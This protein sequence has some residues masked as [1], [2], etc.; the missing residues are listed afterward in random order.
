MLGEPQ[1]GLVSFDEAG[2]PCVGGFR[3]PAESANTIM[4]A[5]A[6]EE[7]DRVKA[8]AERADAASALQDI[9]HA[10]LMATGKGLADVPTLAQLFERELA[11][12]A[13]EQRLWDA[14]LAVGP[15]GRYVDARTGAELPE[16]DTEGPRTTARS[17]TA[18][19]QPVP[20]HDPVVL[21]DE[22]HRWFVAYRAHHDYPRALAAATAKAG[23]AFDVG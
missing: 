2:I 21:A 5:A 4:R 6:L 17:I 3:L 14:G 12:G 1:A 10:H 8:E 18:E 23:R 22:M 20:E 13:V 15:G 7:A 16:V 19:E 9:A 11:R